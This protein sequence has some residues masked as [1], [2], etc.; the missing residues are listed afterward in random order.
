MKTL[1]FKTTITTAEGVAAMTPF[2]NT[3]EPFDG[4]SVETDHPDHLLTVQTVNNQVSNKVIQA[5]ER[6]DFQVEAIEDRTHI[7]IN[8]VNIVVQ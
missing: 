4:F 2:L 7:N 8:E 1:T 5:V 6:A 3:L